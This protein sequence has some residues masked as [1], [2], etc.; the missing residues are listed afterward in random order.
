MT[1]KCLH[2]LKISNYKTSNIVGVAA[3]N[4]AHGHDKISIF[5]L[6][7]YSNSKSKPLKIIHNFLFIYFCFSWNGKKKTLFQFIKRVTSSAL[8]ITDQY[9][10]FRFEERFLRNLFLTKCSNELWQASLVSNLQTYT[11]TSCYLQLVIFTSHSKKGMK[12]DDCFLIYQKDPWSS[13]Y[14][15]IKTK[16]FQKKSV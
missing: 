9:C 16:W 5:L 2:A 12:S 8:K 7:I 13:Y 15:Q 10:Y 11:L 4:K 6:K 14:F 1:V 3:P